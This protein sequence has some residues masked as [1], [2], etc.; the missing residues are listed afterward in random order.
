MAP[1]TA[2]TLPALISDRYEDLAGHAGLGHLC[3]PTNHLKACWLWHFI[4]YIKIR[5]AF[6]NLV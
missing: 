6:L 5:K 4:A 3:L 1:G 2:F